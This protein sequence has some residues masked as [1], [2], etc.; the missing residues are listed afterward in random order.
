MGLHCN[1][2]A[3]QGYELHAHAAGTTMVLTL[4]L[5]SVA[6]PYLQFDDERVEAWHTANRQYLHEEHY[7]KDPEWHLKSLL[8]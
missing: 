8:V 5:P 4:Q 1:L 3:V 2:Q 7:I 6:Y